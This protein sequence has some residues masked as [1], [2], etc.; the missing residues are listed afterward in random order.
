MDAN[1]QLLSTIPEIEQMDV[2]VNSNDE[3]KYLEEKMKYISEVISQKFYGLKT[4]IINVTNIIEE[5]YNRNFMN[6]DFDDEELVEE[7]LD[8]LMYEYSKIKELL[9]KGREIRYNKEHK[10][11]EKDREQLMIRNAFVYYEI[12]PQ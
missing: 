2:S 3:L 7:Q 1:L 6:T 9:K 5:N 4:E 8:I 12:K 10:E 11:K